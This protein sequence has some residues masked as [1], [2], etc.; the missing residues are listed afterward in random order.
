MCPVCST[1]WTFPLTR[2]TDKSNAIPRSPPEE[3]LR[4]DF[5]LRGSAPLLPY[6][7]RRIL[8]RW[9]GAI[10]DFPYRGDGIPLPREALRDRWRSLNNPTTKRGSDPLLDFPGLRMTHF[11]FE[12]CYVSFRL[13][14]TA[15]GGT[16]SFCLL[17]SNHGE[18]GFFVSFSLREELA[19]RVV[20]GLDGVATRFPAGHWG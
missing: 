18:I 14:L 12:N 16:V 2:P 7:G 17:G 11:G 13:A 10:M 15:G 20:E 8:F 4:G 1:G 5:C 6:R 3:I 9:G 19:S